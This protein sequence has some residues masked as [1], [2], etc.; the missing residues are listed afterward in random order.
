MVVIYKLF[1]TVSGH[2]NFQCGLAKIPP[3]AF[4]K[5]KIFLRM[6]PHLSQLGLTRW[7]K[8]VTVLKV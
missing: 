2:P 4:I 7:C 3:N 1:P 5:S 8:C 6:S